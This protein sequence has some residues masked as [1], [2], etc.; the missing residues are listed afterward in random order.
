MSHSPLYP[1]PTVLLSV[2]AFCFSVGMG[3]EPQIKRETEDLHWTVKC[4]EWTFSQWMSCSR[5]LCS[6]PLLMDSTQKTLTCDAAVCH[7]C[8]AKHQCERKVGHR[9]TKHNHPRGN[10]SHFWTSFV[11]RVLHS[12]LPRVFQK[13]QWETKAKI[14]LIRSLLGSLLHT[15]HGSAG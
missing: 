12:L 14:W 8:A 10:V 6:G 3:C 15:D 5:V 13:A 7:L 9:D 4:T 11:I 1:C 2:A